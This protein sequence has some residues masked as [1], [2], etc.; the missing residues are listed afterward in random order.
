M[1]DLTPEAQEAAEKALSVPQM[2]QAVVVVDND[3][4]AKAGEVLT[5]VKALRKE[6]D[7]SYDP[8]IKAAHLT[9]KEAVK[10][11]KIADEPLVKAEKH[12]KP[13]I[14]SYLKKKEQERIEEE[15]R[16]MRE[17]EK[18]A[19]DERIRLAAEAEDAGAHEEAEAIIDE[20]PEPVAP[21]I[22]VDDTPKLD[23][24]SVRQNWKFKIVDESKIPRKY[25]V[26]NEKAIG[27]MARS[28][29]SMAD[30]PGVTFYPE[31]SVAAGAR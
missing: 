15:A 13:Q 25:M 2:A 5:L 19:D 16:L 23:G 27:A 17:A 6:I 3:T 10:S 11:K 26:P 8:I 18:K 31:D 24:V 28:L 12:L 4:F 20:E 30:I 14:G 22:V 7:K 29:K 9:H 21:P 1:S